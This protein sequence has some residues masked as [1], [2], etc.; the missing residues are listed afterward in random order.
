M[1]IN[2]IAYQKN[3]T[4]RVSTRKVTK[5]MTI[6]MLAGQPVLPEALPS[7]NLFLSL[8]SNLFVVQEMEWN[9][10][11]ASGSFKNYSKFFRKCKC[12]YKKYIFDLISSSGPLI[13]QKIAVWKLCRNGYVQTK[14]YWWN[15]K[16]AWRIQM[17]I[18]N[19]IK[20]LWYKL[21]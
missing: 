19:Q 14:K 13:V 2:D 18:K 6:F 11:E 5:M 9:R 7:R 8:N 17:L 1:L 4:L 20:K 15:F 3:L 10:I 16:N 12:K 21:I